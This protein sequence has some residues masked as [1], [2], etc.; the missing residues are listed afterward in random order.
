MEVDLLEFFPCLR[1]AALQQAHEI[2]DHRRFG[3]AQL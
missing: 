1:A 2:L 3:S